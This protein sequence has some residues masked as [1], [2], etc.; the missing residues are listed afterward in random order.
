MPRL[1]KTELD[2]AMTPTETEKLERCPL[3]GSEAALTVCAPN[4]V[5]YDPKVECSNPACECQVRAATTTTAIRRWNTRPAPAGMREALALKI[6]RRINLETRLGSNRVIDWDHAH[7]IV[8]EELAALS[9]PGAPKSNPD[10][11][12]IEKLRRQ[13]LWPYH[14]Q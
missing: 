12:Y 13:K 9:A 8:V 5:Y 2:K 1:R 4:V 11:E 7:E 6:C 14:D 3:C 10:D